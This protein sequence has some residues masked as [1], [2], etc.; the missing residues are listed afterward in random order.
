MRS[1][2]LWEAFTFSHASRGG[3]GGSAAVACD[4]GEG[5]DSISPVAWQLFEVFFPFHLNFKIA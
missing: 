4:G 2:N 3:G 1:K 5:T